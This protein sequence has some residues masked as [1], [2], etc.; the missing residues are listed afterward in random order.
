MVKYTG[1]CIHHNGERFDLSFKIGD[2]DLYRASFLKFTNPMDTQ[3]KNWG[4]AIRPFITIYRGDY[5][6][7]QIH[8]LDRLCD[9]IRLMP[10]DGARAA[11]FDITEATT[12]RACGAQNQKRCRAVA[13]ALGNIGTARFFANSIERLPSHERLEP[14]VAFT[15]GETHLQPLRTRR[16]AH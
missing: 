4:A 9:S 7:L 8:L 14:K 2:Q 6:M 10:V 3:G 15:A 11:G 16:S 13:P 5:R 12:A 1:L